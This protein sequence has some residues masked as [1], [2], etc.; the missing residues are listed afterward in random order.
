MNDVLGQILLAAGNENLGAG[1]LVAAVRLFHC[2]GA[3]QAQVRAA[4][5]L[6]EIHGAGPN[7]FDHLRQEFL[8]LLRRAVRQ[9]RCD[10]ALHQRRI[11][12]ECEIGRGQEFVDDHRQ[13]RG[14]PLPAIFGRRR[15]P[16]PA[17]G[18]QL[19][20]GRLETVRR[21]DPAVG[22]ARTSL[23]IALTIE[24]GEHLGAELAGF[25]KDGL[26]HVGRRVGKARNCCD[27]RY[28]RRHSRETARL[29]R[30]RCKSA[31]LSPVLALSGNSQ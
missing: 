5:R 26:D 15:Q 30:L 12:R 3:Q 19:V 25:Y 8:F 4:M 6:G 24:R 7:A 27:A 11:H 29:R 10:R 18:D 20:I 2:L 9:D 1:N 21:G 22:M 17:A 14:Q 23:D 31:W 28:G 16:D 13:S